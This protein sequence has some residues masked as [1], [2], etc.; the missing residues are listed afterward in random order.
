MT[1][2][3]ETTFDIL[4][5]ITV[6]TLGLKMSL[7]AKNTTQYRLFGYMAIVLGVGDAFHLVPRIYAM[8]TTG[9]ESNASILGFGQFVTSITMT[10]FYIM[11]YH[12]WRMNHKISGQ[13]QLTF[14]IY[15]LAVLR[16][17]LCFAP[18]NQWF[19]LN[20]PLIWS[21]Y[22]N[23]PFTVL[24]CIIL[25]LYYQQSKK[26]KNKELRFMWL[27]IVFS[28]AFYIPVVLFSNIF[29]PIGMLMIPKTCAYVWIVWMGYHQ[30]K[31]L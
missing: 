1:K 31:T 9:M 14:F 16:I 11:L 23:I 4:Y 3:F 21:I 6:I 8:W 2:I 27:A 28:F 7:D 10:I 26:S 24:G 19:S 5:L 15:L 29:P 18:Q 12:I 17:A 22:R 30:K 20:S 25:I 13:K